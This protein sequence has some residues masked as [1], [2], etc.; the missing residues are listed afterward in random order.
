MI[1]F[2]GVCINVSFARRVLIVLAVIA[3]CLA[4]CGINAYQLHK[5]IS[6]H[7]LEPIY[8]V[9]LSGVYHS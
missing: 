4:F 3:A 7:L 5:L 1:R 9:L 8:L 6:M 2:S